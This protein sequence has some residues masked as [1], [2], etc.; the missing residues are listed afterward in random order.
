MLVRFHPEADDEF[1]EALAWYERHR[2]GLGA[3]FS[4]AVSRSLERIEL[5]PHAFPQW[6]EI[7]PGRRFIIRRAVV[8]RFSYVIS[9]EER[10]EFL[11]MLAVA[12]AKRRPLYWLRRTA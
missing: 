4:A 3:E 10:P 7:S 6:F 5:S 11:L 1:A 2:T 9:F 12:H 8:D